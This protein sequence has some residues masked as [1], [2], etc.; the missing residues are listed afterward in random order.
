MCPK[1]IQNNAQADTSVN[2]VERLSPDPKHAIRPPRRLRLSG[3]P[4]DVFTGVGDWARSNAARRR[5]VRTDQRLKWWEIF[6]SL[7]E[8][9]KASSLQSC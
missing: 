4:D 3:R 1:R 6:L 9:R 5:S 2:H 7:G 8:S